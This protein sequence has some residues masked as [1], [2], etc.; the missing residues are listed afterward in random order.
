MSRTKKTEDTPKVEDVKMEEKPIRKERPKRKPFKEYDVKVSINNLCL[1]KGPGKEFPKTGLCKP[2]RQT[3]VAERNGYGKR[4][5]GLW[6]ALEF[7][8]KI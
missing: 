8:E 6:I 3:I 1:R 2:G 5:D 7:C 4:P